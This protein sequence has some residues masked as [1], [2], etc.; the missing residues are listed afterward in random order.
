MVSAGRLSAPVSFCK[1]AMSALELTVFSV[2][3]TPRA[4]SSWRPLVQASH[5]VVVYSVTG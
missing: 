4:V 5:A 2:K 1:A 3:G